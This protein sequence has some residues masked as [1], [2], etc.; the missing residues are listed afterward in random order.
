MGTTTNSQFAVANVKTGEV[1]NYCISTIGAG[2]ATI[3][4]PNGESVALSPFGSDLE[5]IT[6]II[7]LQNHT[8]EKIAN[9]ASVL[10]W[11]K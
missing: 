10:G 6:L 9:N 11:M 5:P 1:T 3:W 7:D 8:V 2:A 4:S